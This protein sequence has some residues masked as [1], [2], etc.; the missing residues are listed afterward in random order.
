MQIVAMAG[1]RPA[2][3]HSKKGLPKRELRKAKDPAARGWV[4]QAA[5]AAGAAGN[6]VRPSIQVSEPILNRV[7]TLNSYCMPDGLAS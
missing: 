2:M 4:S 6:F 1:S 5:L 3:L 7:V